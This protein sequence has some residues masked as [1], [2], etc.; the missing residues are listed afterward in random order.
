T[1]FSR[2]WSSDVCSSDLHTAPELVEQ[3]TRRQT[4]LD[5]IH[6]LV[7]VRSCTL[8]VP[9][10]LVGRAVARI[11]IAHACRFFS[12]CFSSFRVSVVRRGMMDSSRMRF[13][14]PFTMAYPM[15]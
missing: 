7:Q 15:A 11:G 1:R 3:L 13:L 6:R 10:D 12:H 9:A 5:C 14:A 4:P 8:D 2:D